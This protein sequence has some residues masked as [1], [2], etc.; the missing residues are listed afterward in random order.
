[1]STPQEGFQKKSI[2]K[3]SSGIVG[4]DQILFGGLPTGRTTLI[5]GGPGTGKTVFGLEFLYRGALAGEPG[6]LITFEEEAEEVRRNAQAIGWDLAQLEQQ[7]KLFIMHAELPLDLILSGEFTINGLLAILVGQVQALGAQRIVIDAID[8][9]LNLF[10]DRLRW[11]NQLHTLHHWLRTQ[12]LT[13][14]ITAKNSGNKKNSYPF[15]DYLL[16]CVVHLDQRVIGQVMTRRLR[17]MKYRGSGFLSNEYPYLISDHGIE[18]IPISSSQLHQQAI[19]AYMSTGNKQFDKLLGGGFRT[20]AGIVLAGSSG[21]GKTTLVSSIA[22]AASKQ[23]KKVLFISFEE[24]EK[25]IVNTMLSSGIDL[26]PALDANNLK[27]LNVFPE[28][29]GVEEHLFNISSTIKSYEPDIFILEGI[30]ATNRIGSEKAA[31]DL[32]VRLIDLCK[33]NAIT[34]ILTNQLYSDPSNGSPIIEHISGIGISSLIDTLILLE[35]RWEQNSHMRRLLIIKSRGSNHSHQYHT[36]NITDHGIDI[37]ASQLDE[38]GLS[39]KER[40]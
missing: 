7:K 8:R 22:S 35:Q 39:K 23:G 4:L 6:I 25:A 30:S 28:S 5:S 12:R 10:S 38:F 26:Q 24:S 33:E 27:F 9:I 21:T 32:L 36:F 31:F 11:Q 16:D 20:G 1:M 14:V 40:V 34:S 17:V 29:V 15:L 3:T 13:A 2:P 37:N 19:G 18:I